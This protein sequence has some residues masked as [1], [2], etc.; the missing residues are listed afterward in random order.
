ML[1]DG[2]MF[3]NGGHHANPTSVFDHHTN[4][5]TKKIQAMSRSRWYPSTVALGNGDVFTAL[6][7]GGGNYPEV[8]D[9]IALQQPQPHL[10]NWSS[11]IANAKERFVV[12]SAF[13]QGAVLDMET[14]LVWERSPS[15]KL[16]TWLEAIGDC[17]SRIVGGRLGWRLPTIEELASLIDPT[18]SR[19]PLLPRGHPF[20]KVQSGGQLYWSSTSLFSTP[21]N[22][23]AMKPSDGTVGVNIKALREGFVWCVR[24]GYGHSP[25]VLSE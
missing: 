22:A 11:K 21:P 4:V 1:E 7:T 23:F 8:G 18:Q 12:L 17:Y 10:K 13:S 14:G 15:T 6:G 19:P 16:S 9:R 25:D 20:T 24:G 3:S 5:R 2:R